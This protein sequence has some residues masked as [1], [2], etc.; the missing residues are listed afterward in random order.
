MNLRIKTPKRVLDCDGKHSATPLSHA[1]RTRHSDY[2]PPAR[3][4]R[5]RCALPA[6]SK[7]RRLPI[8]LP[9]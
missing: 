7:T 2:Q 1:Q 5:R 3:K 9:R 6:Q 4:R 8:K